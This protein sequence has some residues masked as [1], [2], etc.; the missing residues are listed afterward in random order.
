MFLR[1]YFAHRLLYLEQE[2]SVFYLTTC[3]QVLKWFENQ[4]HIAFWLVLS[5]FLIGLLNLEWKEYY[6]LFDG[7]F[8]LL[9]TN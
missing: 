1:L 2:E 4:I 3:L 5:L 8:C 6:V 7:I 9:I